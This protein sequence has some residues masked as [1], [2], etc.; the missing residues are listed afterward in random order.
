MKPFLLISAER[1]IYTPEV[2][3][4]RTRELIAHLA[5]NNTPWHP[6]RE[7]FGG[8]SRL[9]LVIECTPD[10]YLGAQCVRTAYR[11]GQDVLVYVNEDLEA[12]YLALIDQRTMIKT[13]AGRWELASAAYAAEAGITHFWV[14]PGLDNE[15]RIILR[16]EPRAAPL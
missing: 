15:M 1:S 9:V 8:Y 6:L 7:Y 13:K 2:N 12:S 4:E 11:Y 3:D 5:A 16:V 10:E 14:D